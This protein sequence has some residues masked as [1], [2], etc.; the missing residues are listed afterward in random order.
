MQQWQSGIEGTLDHELWQRPGESST[1]QINQMFRRAFLDGEHLS[2]I[3]QLSPGDQHFPWAVTLVGKHRRGKA[4][5]W[6]EGE[7]GA[8]R[9]LRVKNEQRGQMGKRPSE[10]SGSKD[11]HAGS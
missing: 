1:A 3:G 10:E 6:W 4:A 5:G 8:P 7:R 2:G 11:T 9:R